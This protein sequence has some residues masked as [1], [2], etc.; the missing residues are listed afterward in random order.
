VTRPR[1][2]I[3]EDEA[4]TA[5]TLRLYL[6]AAG[7]DVDHARD[8]GQALAAARARTPDLVLLDL[9]LPVCD[10]WTVARRLRE[11][12][13]VPILMLSA[14]TS[15]ADRL[16]GL[17]LGAD[18]YV[19]KP[20][21]PREIVLR[22]RAILRRVSPQFLARGGR[23]RLRSGAL[24]VDCEAR[25]AALAGRPL[26]LPPAELAVLATLLRRPGHV[27][28][29]DELAR[30]AFGDDWDAFDRTIDAHISRL[31]RKLFAAGDD[32]GRITTVFGVGYQLE[33]RDAG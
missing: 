27:F 7:F 18:D 14:R 30:A 13:A 25:T 24:V 12:S 2:L 16:N 5:E 1:I 32:D 10:G 3:V 33:A 6:A 28:T 23:K 31:R 8:G 20:F 22:V 29:R 19:T 15:E 9:M 21:S 26:T 11:T 17:D 4:K